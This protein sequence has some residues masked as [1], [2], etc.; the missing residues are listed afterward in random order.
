MTVQTEPE[1]SEQEEATGRRG[2]S[3][4]ESD[5]RRLLT[6]GYAEGKLDVVDDVVESG[7]TSYGTPTSPGIEGVAGIKQQVTRVRTAIYDFDLEIVEF[8]VSGDEFEAEWRVNGRLERRLLGR[9]PV[10]ELG[11]AGEEPSGSQVRISGVVHGQATAKGI[12]EWFMEW[13]SDTF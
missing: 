4:I 2:F 9:E 6:Q 5:V 8:E 1:P 7:V 3:N 11:A 13:D 12:S 10:C